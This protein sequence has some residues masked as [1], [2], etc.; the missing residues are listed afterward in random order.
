MDDSVLKRIDFQS[1]LAIK[2][3][4]KIEPLRNEAVIQVFETYSML[5]TPLITAPEPDGTEPPSVLPF[6]N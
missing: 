1:A 6:C 4:R 3:K 2:T 5:A